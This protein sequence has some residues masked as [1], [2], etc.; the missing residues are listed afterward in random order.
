MHL[1]G[2]GRYPIVD[3]ELQSPASAQALTSLLGAGSDQLIPR[4]AGCSY[5]D[6][7][8]G[9]HV[10]SSRFLDNF[11]SLNEE[12]GLLHCGAGLTLVQLLAILI[13][14]GLFLPVMPGTRHV[15]VGGAIAA[16][17]HGKNHHCDGCFGDHV[18]SLTL[19]LANGELIRCSA[20]QNAE[21]FHATCGGMGLTGVIVDA[22]LRLEK[23][24]VF[25]STIKLR[26]Q[27]I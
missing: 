25:L 9:K 12:Q 19:A 22:Q 7:A 16:D 1:H 17:I 18:E 3:A 20:K 5:G 27:K 23:V 10:I 4:G 8:L 15:S 24:S 14:K 13:P 2:W 26:P 6:S 11:Y 21:L